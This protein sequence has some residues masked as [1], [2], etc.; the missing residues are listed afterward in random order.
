MSDLTIH[1][2]ELAE[3]S[4]AQIVNL[5]PARLQ[6]LDV[7]LNELTAWAKAAR[8]KMNAALE[9]RFGQAARQARISAGKDF[10][11]VH[12]ED[13]ALR[14]T[15]DMRKIVSWD[16]PKLKEIAR[17][18]AEIGDQ[19]EDY[20]DVEFTVAESRYTNW[21]AALREQ[22]EAARTVKPGKTSFRLA[23]LQGAP[24]E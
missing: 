3:L 7:A 17:R 15:H 20:L 14:V 19:V 13:G 10:G 16:Q 2:A 18:I 21:P 12:L 11:V 9:Q 4:V 23:L 6:E 24:N 8:D 5:P 22:F 1:T